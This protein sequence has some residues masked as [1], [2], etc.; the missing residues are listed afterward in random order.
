[1]LSGT[2]VFHC[3]PLKAFLLFFLNGAE[4]NYTPAVRNGELFPADGNLWE[5]ARSNPRGR[6]PLLVQITRSSRQDFSQTPRDRDFWTLFGGDT[7]RK[8]HKLTRLFEGL[9][10]SY[11]CRQMA[12]VIVRKKWK[13]RGGACL[14]AGWV[15]GQGD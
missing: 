11:Y 1:M 3:F 12:M 14:T 15:R 8:R 4:F 6:P 13:K 9:R 7:S 5:M 10:S 2:L